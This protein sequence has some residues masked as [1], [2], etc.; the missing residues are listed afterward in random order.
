MRK[1]AIF[2]LIFL[3]LL[4]TVL[5]IYLDKV[6]IPVKLKQIAID[7]AQELLQRR[8]TIGELHFNPIRGFVVDQVT[9]FKKDS[10]EIMLQIDRAYFKIVYTSLFQDKRIFIPSIT[11]ENPYW[12][13][14]R[15]Q[16]GRWEFQDLM[17]SGKE[18]KPGEDLFHTWIGG[19][20]VVNGT[21]KFTD[22]SQNEVFMEI[23]NAVHLKTNLSFRKTVVFGLNFNLPRL[24][25]SVAA[26]GRYD[27]PENQWAAELKLKNLPLEEY[28]EPYLK[29]NNIRLTSGTIQTAEL[30]LL[31]DENET[32]QLTGNIHMQAP[33]ITLDPEVRLKAGNIRFPKGELRF[34]GGNFELNGPF[35]I[36]RADLDLGPGKKITGEINAPFFSMTHRNAKTIVETEL[37]LTQGHVRLPQ[38]MFNGDMEL[39]GARLVLSKKDTLFKSRLQL[40]DSVITWSKDRVLKGSP[41]GELDLRYD[42]ETAK[43]TYQGSAAFQD[44]SLDGIAAK[45]KTAEHIHGAI[46]FETGKVQTERLSLTALNVPLE[47][48]GRMEDFTRPLLDIKASAQEFPLETLAV[49]FPDFFEKTQLAV[50]GLAAVTL[51]FKGHPDPLT[52]PQIDVQALLKNTTLMG[53]KLP[54]PLTALSGEVTYSKNLLTWKDLKGSF[55]KKPYT[56]TGQLVNFTRPSIETTLSSP[57]VELASKF[58]I[59]RDSLDIASL[60]GRYLNSKFDL[61]GDIMTTSGMNPAVSLQGTIGL[62]LKDLPVFLP[63]IKE[64]FPALPSEGTLNVGGRVNGL[65]KDWRNWEAELNAQSPELKI[66]GYRLK[67]ILMNFAQAGGIIHR[68]D[69]TGDFYNGTLKASGT[70]DLT[71]KAMP[72]QLTF[73]IGKTDL[74]KLKDDSAWKEQNLAGLL[75]LTGSLQGAMTDQSQMRGKGSISV[76]KGRLWQLNLLTG[77]GKFL[78]IPEFRNIVF[79]QAAA[80]FLITDQRV[81]TDNLILKSAAVDFLGGGWITYQGEINF[82]IRSRFSEKTIAESSSLKKLTTLFIMQTDNYL[83]IKIYHTLKEPKYVVVPAKVNVLEKATDTIIGGLQT[84]L[85]EIP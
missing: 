67:N 12:D 33:D 35:E 58:F 77:L 31:R 73:G 49:I 54:A 68:F 16:D 37:G 60:K 46:T 63:L 39:S 9:I 6:F 36:T 66:A 79:D 3:L 71:Q 38:M 44:A 40:K 30:R 50:K 11:V 4:G 48:Q 85:E 81:S 5:A 75:S 61:T 1:K 41:A 32:L 82:Y 25:A 74:A 8:V 45:I 19:V 78:F 62:D 80:D 14:T 53:A 56:L 17:P 10:D 52:S 59:L 15:Q 7:Q 2:I 26:K 18:T 57:D 76:E 22:R 69:L 55:L 51:N 84:I 43:L 47:L 65:L 27:I 64:K 23:I 24:F 29:K 42:H 28:W 13:L 72:Y 21:I 83:H 34:A 70:A 20:T